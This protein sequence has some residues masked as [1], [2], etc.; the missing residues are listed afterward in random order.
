MRI[1][2]GVF[3]ANKGVDVARDAT[4]VAAHTLIKPRRF[5]EVIYPL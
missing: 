5:I 4:A 1:G 2:F 3:S